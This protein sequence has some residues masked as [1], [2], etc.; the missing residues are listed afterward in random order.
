MKR[1]EKNILV[2]V[3]MLCGFAA[4]AQ[5]APPAAYSGSISVN[6]VREWNATA[7]ESSPDTLITR[8]IK[9]VKQ[10][11]MYFDGLGRPLQTVIKQGSMVTGASAVDLVM[12]VVYDSLG[13]E[14]YKYHPFAANN[15]GGN[16]YI[17]DGVFKQN[18]FQQQ[19][20]FMQQQFGSQ[21]QTYYYGQTNFEASPLNRVQKIL[22]AGNS[23]V[24]A[25]RGVTSSYWSNATIDS[26]RIWTVAD[27]TNNWGTYG[28]SAWYSA[29]KL[30]KNITEDE[31]GKQVI[32]FK[33]MEDKVILKK[34]QLTAIADTGT[35]K[36]Y[37]GWLCTYYIYDNLNNLRCVV[38]PRGVELLLAN[39][40]NINAL[41][42]AILNE[43]C[44]RY[45]YDHRYRMIRKKVP[46]AGEVRM[47]YDKWDRLVL[48]QDANLRLSNKWLF[49]KYDSLNR[50]ILTGTYVNNTDTAL[51]TMQNYLNTQNLGRNENYTPAGSLPMYSLNQSFP[52]TTYSDVLTANYYDDYAWTSGVPAAFRDYD[53][54]FNGYFFSASNSTFPYP[55]SM[56]PSYNT[57]GFT[58]GTIVKTVDGTTAMTTTLFYDEKGRIIQSK[59]ESYE[60]EC[61]MTTTQYTFSG[62][63][64]MTM[65]HHIKPGTP[66][67]YIYLFTYYSY[68]DLGRPTKT[69]KLVSAT[70]DGHH[71]NTGEVVT[72]E[73]AYNALGQL[74]KKWLGRTK[75]SSGTYTLDPIDS[76][77]YDY[78]IRGWMLGMNRTYVKD[79]NSVANYFGFDLGYEK[80]TIV[81]NGANKFYSGKQFN[82]NIGGM[83]WK[84]T[85]DDRARKYDFTYDAANRLAN[86][87]FTQLTNNTFSLSAGI[88]FSVKGLTYDANGNI[89]TMNQKGWKPGNSVTIDSLLYTYISN[90]NRLQNVLDRKNDTATRMGDFRS[91]KAY[92]DVLSQAKTTGATDYNYDANGNLVEDKNKNIVSISYNHLNLPEIIQINGKGSIQYWYDATGKKLK[93]QVVDWTVSPSKVINTLY[94]SGFVY[95]DDTLQYMGHEEGRIRYKKEDTSLVF[96]YF[97]KDH[98]GNVRMVLTDEQQ[99]NVYPLVTFEDATYSNELTYYDSV[100]QE[101]VARPGSFFNSTSN[102]NK[103]Q[104]LRKSTQS[105]GTGKLLKV[106]ATD[107]LHVKVDYFTPN[108][109]TDNNNANG[110]N[111]VLGTLASMLNAVGA[112]APLKGSGAT[113]IDALDN[114]GTFVDFL[115]PQGSG[116]GSSMPKAY[117]NILFFDEQ[118]N[119]VQQNSE[120]IQVTT[121]GSGQQIFRI[122]GN[123]KVAT[124]NGY[125]YIYVS[126]E[127]NNF[128]YF[129]NLQISHERGAILEE[130]HYYPFGLTMAAISSKA[131]KSNYTENKNKFNK[132]SEL[133]N[134]EFTDGNGLEWYATQFRMYDPQIGRW[135]APDS[136]PDMMLSLY[137]AFE[138]NPILK[139][140]PLGDT[141]TP[142]WHPPMVR[143]NNSFNPFAPLMYQGYANVKAAS[144]RTQYNKEAAKL[145]PNDKQGRAE[146]KERARVNTPEPYRTIVEKGRPIDAEKA[147][148]KDPAFKGNATKTN[149]EVNQTMKTTA[150]LGKFFLISGAG[151]S[152]YT[153]ANSDNPIKETVTEGAGWGMAMYGGGQ[154][155]LFGLSI[156]GGNPYAGFGFGVLGSAGGFIAGKDGADLAIKALPALSLGAGKFNNEK[157]IIFHI[158]H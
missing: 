17:S 22:P 45:E 80:D 61:D 2:T 157:G 102:G 79:T 132:G 64:L 57:Q 125:A 37:T 92:M 117:L 50:P 27:V 75:N 13:R 107:R 112:P 124:K 84:S 146:L 53:N 40:W 4:R 62:Q 156:S 93:K 32:E 140:D 58:T 87:D 122:S 9:D 142:A 126:N 15:T 44:F 85:G 135:H 31:H 8:P 68:D 11:T 36:G 41:S 154:G 137:S 147:K 88:D 114:P 76:L 119:F 63:V 72:A 54:S 145:D 110:L 115:A 128:V 52:V 149:I 133:Q 19:E 153:I 109:A 97:V 67:D 59:A 138:N 130:T 14:V 47:V 155:T 96:D 106:M 123:A 25:N 16:T 94:I 56:V 21:G 91:S 38:Q 71:S 34:V 6:Y 55:Q 134:K 131:L 95:Q 127:S 129:D 69:K 151:H 81:I 150:V 116:V 65:L 48:T 30:Y 100:D 86:A 111:S 28:T 74:K 66:Y 152:I 101:R 3:L 33:D 1:V 46:G 139:N 24:G 89:L 12:P 51:H 121:K 118:F 77:R 49:T 103:V 73:Y 18:P 105:I 5:Q 98:L 10:T 39:S 99:T 20:V 70:I 143:P 148:V 141:T 104:L 42:G 108:D 90:S 23:W 82:G 7:P 83:L 29:G 136:K 144:V 35:G 78:N 158:P 43:Q 113:I 60:G 120:I 26:V